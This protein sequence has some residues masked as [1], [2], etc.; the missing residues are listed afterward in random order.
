MPISGLLS[1]SWTPQSFKLA[2][3]SVRKASHFYEFSYHCA[4]LQGRIRGAYLFDLILWKNNE[5]K[6]IGI[7]TSFKAMKMICLSQIL[8]VV[9]PTSYM[10]KEMGR[11]RRTAP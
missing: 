11:T 1:F 4:R 5:M 9:L 2:S 7:S 8:G 3:R 6:S 10:T